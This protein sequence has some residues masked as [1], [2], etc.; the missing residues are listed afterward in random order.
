MNILSSILTA[1]AIVSFLL[2][3]AAAAPIRGGV[4]VESTKESA[5]NVDGSVVD[6]S[7]NGER[8]NLRQ[9]EYSDAIPALVGSAWVVF[10][11]SE[12]N[13]TLTE[14]QD[15]DG[16]KKACDVIARVTTPNKD[17]VPEV[18]TVRFA[19]DTFLNSPSIIV[20]SGVYRTEISMEE[21]ES[22]SGPPF[23]GNGKGNGSGG[24]V[25]R[26]KLNGM[27]LEASS[28]NDF[29]NYSAY[30]ARKKRAIQLLNDNNIFAKCE[31][32][33]DLLDMAFLTLF[34]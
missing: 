25:M 28:Y 20:H 19:S 27:E 13:I 18:V 6:R 3:G 17:G 34:W 10:E 29:S 26:T 16:N 2:E 9:L 7:N 30:G 22:Q 4:E 21:D 24:K 11:E 23:G 8:R 14:F 5:E 15:N 33:A 32:A 31:E 1:A 12:I